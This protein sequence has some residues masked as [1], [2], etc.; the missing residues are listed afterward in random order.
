M[1]PRIPANAK[2][3]GSNNTFPC[4]L[5]CLGTVKFGYQQRVMWL[6]PEGSSSMGLERALHNIRESEAYLQNHEHGD[7]ACRGNG[8]C[9]DGRQSCRDCYHDRATQAQ[10]HSMRLKQSNAGLRTGCP[11]TWHM[12]CLLCVTTEHTR[13]SA[14]SHTKQF[15]DQRTR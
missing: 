5:R 7:K 6:A 15:S 2:H 4:R 12:S 13:V 14:S 11:T 10:S 8:G 1:A 9:T 3:R